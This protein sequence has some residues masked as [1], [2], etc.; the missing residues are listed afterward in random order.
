MLLGCCHSFIKCSEAGRCVHET[1]TRLHGILNYK[2]CLYKENLDKGHNFYTE[3]NENNR[4]RAE[5]YK[6]KTEE[7]IKEVEKGI[8]ENI[9]TV[10]R[11]K[12][13]SKTYIEIPKRLFSVGKRS[14][15][16]GYTYNLN[17]EE[18]KYFIKEMENYEIE[19][20]YLDETEK[21]F[22]E[23]TEE[24]TRCNCKVVFTLNDQQY[25]I[26]NYDYK[27]IKKET[28]VKVASYLIKKGINAE[29][30]EIMNFQGSKVHKSLS[31]NNKEVESKKTKEKRKEQKGSS[32]SSVLNGQMSFF[33]IQKDFKIANEKEI[34]IT[35][36]KYVN[37][38]NFVKSTRIDRKCSECEMIIKAG[39]NPY[40]TR[41]C[42]IE[43]APY[44]VNICIKCIEK[45]EQRKIS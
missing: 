32:E 25:N 42:N 37:S 40:Y 45:K 15:Y 34:L 4:A 1:D 18:R 39:N 31:I 7:A 43:T 38:F 6:A 33:D 36:N 21:F 5:E 44:I 8:Q 23:I 13:S 17:E 24:N 20:T 3:Y 29:I 14:S 9:E 22:D 30:E 11:S 27:G 26:S 2:E 10:V 41:V 16:N 28:A 12:K 35:K 19:C